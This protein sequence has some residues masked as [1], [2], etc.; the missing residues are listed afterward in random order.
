MLPGKA[1]RNGHYKKRSRRDLWLTSMNE[2]IVPLSL[3]GLGV[4]A[5]VDA[6]LPGLLAELPDAASHVAIS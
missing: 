5:Y 2:L 1:D 4:L 6:D 3:A